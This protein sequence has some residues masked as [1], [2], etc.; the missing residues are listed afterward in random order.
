MNLRL[1]ICIFCLA[2]SA[3]HAPAQNP[4]DNP[5]QE[6]KD[7]EDKGKAEDNDRAK[8]VQDLCAAAQM[9]PK[10]K[11]FVDTCN[12]YRAG[13]NNDDT[14]FLAIAIQAYKSHDLDKAESNARLVTSYDEKL[15][16]QARFLLD[17]IRNE[18]L[19]NQVKAAWDKGDFNAVSTLTQ[20]ITN[21]NLRATAN[22]YLNN[23]NLYNGY[24]DQARKIEKDNPTEAIRQLSLAQSLNPNG[25]SN[26]AGMIA[27][28]QKPSQAKSVAPPVTPAPK[29]DSAAEI[30]K[31]ISKLI[32][33]ASGA[34]K[35]G[36]LLNALKDYGLVLK[37][38]PSNTEAQNDIARIGDEIRSDPAAAK[39]E[40]TSAIRYFY[41]SQFD[42]AQ[43]AL[44][45]YLK[46]ADTAQNP[47]VAYFY[48]GAAMLEES[49][50]E[51]PRANWQGPS[52]E[53]HVAFKQARKANYS[54]VREY[55]SPALLKIWDSTTP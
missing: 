44:R 4:G 3:V 34:E 15:S 47:G 46:S 1:S 38:Q 43:T 55:V 50:L 11:K 10:N 21:A 5:K 48:L 20:S 51:T 22:A 8:Q 18:R 27:E 9:E 16:G 35:Q 49:M 32:G 19:L 28:L 24:I 2:L 33:D 31:K 25:P 37:L 12:S 36:D 26:P 41:H 42:D 6:A 40:L 54:P 30:A 17:L 23:V 45:D 52:Q 14:A 29:V 13:L 53:A 39:N 7:L